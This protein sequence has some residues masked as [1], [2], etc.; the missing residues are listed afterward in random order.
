M[1]DLD[2]DHVG[3]GG[4]VDEVDVGRT[5]F[6]SVIILPVLH[7]NADDF[8]A[9]LFEQIRR[10][11]RVHAAAQAHHD[12]LLAVLLVH[13]GVIIGVPLASWCGSWCRPTAQQ[14]ATG[15]PV[16]GRAPPRRQWLLDFG[17]GGPIALYDGKTAVIVAVRHHKEVAGET[18]VASLLR[19]FLESMARE[20]A[21]RGVDDA[22]GG[23]S[24]SE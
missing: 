12:S 20:L 8:V 17:K 23:N 18:R 15:R 14:S 1:F 22:G 24:A 16:A 4:G 6:V 19:Q 7:E 21:R 3:D 11:R 9:L 13:R 10:H 2:A 5:E